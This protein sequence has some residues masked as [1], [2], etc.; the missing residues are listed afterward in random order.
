MN[1]GAT[2]SRELDAFYDSEL[3][4]LEGEFESRRVRRLR[5]RNLRMA[6][7]VPAWLVLAAFGYLWFRWG[8][9]FGVWMLAFA[10]LFCGVLLGVWAWLPFL[11]HY[12]QIKTDIL[13]RLVR[14]FGDLRIT[15]DAQLPMSEFGASALIP[16]HDKVYVE[17]LLEGSFQG[18]PL[19]AA[20]ITLSVWQ[21]RGGQ[22][23]RTLITVFRGLLVEF[24]SGD[25]S[26]GLTLVGSR[27]MFAKYF[28][29]PDDAGLQAGPV[30]GDFEVHWS[31]D[32]APVV[33]VNE[34]LFGRLAELRKQF[35]ADR[36]GLSLWDNRLL[37][38]IE[39]KK[40]LFEIPASKRTDLKEAV[41]L[42]AADLWKVL[43]IADLLEVKGTSGTP[44][45]IADNSQP[46][47]ESPNSEWDKGAY[48]GWGCLWIF[49]VWIAAMAAFAYQLR[50]RFERDELFVMSFFGGLL[51][52]LGLFALARGIRKFSIGKLIV[53]A[54]L[55][56]AAAWILF[57]KG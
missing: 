55:L 11:L 51:G 48:G 56:G 18:V 1:D 52:A 16:R 22:G 47:S 23:R 57:A 32:A 49:L 17:D 3:K 24:T 27:G 14:F 8:A 34:R 37:L 31:P 7:A 20:E 19:R 5:E 54:L 35:D 15:W 2:G 30:G 41:G 36:V 38:L 50:D 42:V 39:K 12:G 40:D 13:P 29:L 43:S 45:P 6:A 21:S 4:P 10:L 25:V 26:A 33:P 9:D 46:V 44:E 53:A 28:Q